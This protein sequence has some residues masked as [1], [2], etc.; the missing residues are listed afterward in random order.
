MVAHSCNNRGTVGMI[1]FLTLIFMLATARGVLASTQMTMSR[2]VLFTRE[3]FLI[4]GTFRDT[5]TRSVIQC[6]SLC[7]QQYNGCV[8]ILVPNPMCSNNTAVTVGSCQ[9]VLTMSEI[10][11]NPRLGSHSKL[12]YADI[13]LITTVITGKCV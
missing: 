1:A 5:A 12:F 4:N 6:A 9:L 3:V 11:V 10:V 13:N 8:G 7:S 2:Y